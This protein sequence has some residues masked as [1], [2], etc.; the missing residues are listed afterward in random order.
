MQTEIAKA[1]GYADRPGR[2]DVERFMKKYYLLAKEVGDLTRIFAAALEERHKK[3]K[4]LAAIRAKIRRPKTLDGFEIEGGRVNVGSDD[5]FEMQPV[6]MLRLFHL[7][8][9]QGLDIH[10]EALRLVRR[11]LKLIGAQMRND[12][13]E[14]RRVGKACVS[15]C[16]SRLSPYH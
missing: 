14:E 8:Q 13:S 9:E 3:K 6:K 15:T 5:L 7:A 4:P 1:M 10:P 12:R 11:H 16:R 2:S